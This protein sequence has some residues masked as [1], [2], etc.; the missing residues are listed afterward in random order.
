MMI[1]LKLT[2]LTQS[3]R[4]GSED[5]GYNTTGGLDYISDVG[6]SLNT[7]KIQWLFGSL[8]VFL[9]VMAE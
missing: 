4:V 5:S 1:M 2:S 7:T 9:V 8:I 6:F 3:Q